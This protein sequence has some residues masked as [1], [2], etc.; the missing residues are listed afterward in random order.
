M[1]KPPAASPGRAE[2]PQ[3]HLPAPAPPGL[4][5]LLL[6]KSRRG[7]R[8]RRAPATSPMFVSSTR[9]GR[10]RASS[11]DGG[12]PSSPK[13]TCIGQ[14][15][16]QRN[17][18][19]K[20]QKKAKPGVGPAKTE[21]ASK[22]GYCRCLKKAFLCG[23]LFEFDRRRKSRRSKHAAAPPPEVE[24]EQRA[25][26][27]RSPWVFSSRDVAVAAAPAAP[28]PAGAR[29]ARGEEEEVEVF[30]SVGR[31][32]APADE[33]ELADGG[34]K[35]LEPEAEL[36][37][38]ATTTP[39]KNALLLMRC[40][41]APQNRTTPLTARFLP[42]DAAAPSTPTRDVASPA[43]LLS[44]S[45]RK[46][47][48]SPRKAAEDKFSP[49]P[50]PSPRRNS[51]KMLLLLDDDE[52]DGE[53]RQGE[54][55]ALHDDQPEVEEDEYEEEDDEMRCSSARPLVLQRCKSEPS[56]TAA[57]KMA[58]AGPANDATTAG[59]FWANGGSSGR[60]RHAPATVALTGQ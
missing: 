34:R 44:P 4:A 45:P 42:V 8:S 5:R 16:M 33:E 27:R 59:C 30:R 60:R 54:L 13:V 37:S 46:Q 9:G 3:Q 21:K 18:G 48:P 39:P 11:G 40:R 36:V 6:S 31:K 41:S 22:G 14:V 17:K 29:S 10:S 35:E 19:K 51:E 47:A 23:G 15:R 56:T 20:K 12:E 55:A 52:D 38:S 25:S 28:K 57:A 50:S 43:A 7:G 58:A 24:V 26:G 2:K 53:M 32:S 49:A 1:M